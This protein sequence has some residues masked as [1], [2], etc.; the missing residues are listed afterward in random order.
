M[1]S[2]SR[3]NTGPWGGIRLR[4]AGRAPGLID[5]GIVS[6]RIGAPR[7]R[8]RCQIG[9]TRGD[10]PDSVPDRKREGNGEECDGESTW[11]EHRSV[12]IQLGGVPEEPQDQP[13][14]VS[15]G[16]SEAHSGSSDGRDAERRRFDRTAS[17]RPARRKRLAGIAAV[18]ADDG[19]GDE[20]GKGGWGQRR[21]ADLPT[22]NKLV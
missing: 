11:S 3:Q 16:M 20:S 21:G 4:G 9:V 17:G 12:S 14:M 6:L 7:V 8:A 5:Q 10:F 2:L 19:N 15:S 22:R 1:K 13:I 18:R